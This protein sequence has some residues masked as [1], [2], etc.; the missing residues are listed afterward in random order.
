[1][2]CNVT[3]R[4]R[5]ARRTRPRRLAA[6]SGLRAKWHVLKQADWTAALL[7]GMHVRLHVCENVCRSRRQGRDC[8]GRAADM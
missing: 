2:F 4:I 5:G 8:R 3:S 1:M 6:S 7:D